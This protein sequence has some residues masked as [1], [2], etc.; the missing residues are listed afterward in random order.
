MGAAGKFHF[1]RL[2]DHHLFVWLAEYLCF[3]SALSGNIE[4]DD[5]AMDTHISW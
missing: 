4:E 1:N 2:Q 5:L 3:N